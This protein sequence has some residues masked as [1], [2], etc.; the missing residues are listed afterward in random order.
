MKRI[1]FVDDEP[2][3]LEALRNSLRGKRKTW[4]MVFKDSGASALLEF[5]HAHAHHE[6][7]R[8]SEPCEP[9]V[10]A[11]HAHR[12]FRPRGGVDAGTCGADGSQLLG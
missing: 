9:A 12:S 4:D 5:G 8:V 7:S 2:M 6:R 10:S 11:G 3:V 1:L